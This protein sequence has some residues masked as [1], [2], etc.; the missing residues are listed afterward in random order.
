[1]FTQADREGVRGWLVDR[2]QADPRV[3]AAA[4]MGSGADGRE[5]PWSD[6]DLALRLGPAVDLRTVADDWTKQIGAHLGTVAHVDVWARGAL[7]RVFVLPDTLQVDVSF[8][9]DEDFA[10][11]GPRFRLV[12]GDANEPATP[13]TTTTA[14]DDTVG[15]A[16]LHAIHVRSSLA[17]GRVLQALY[18][19]NAVR[20]YVV[21]LACRRH[22]LPAHEGRGVDD[23]PPDLTKHLAET[24]PGSLELDRLRDAFSRLSALL[25]RE[26]RYVDPAV[27]DRLDPLL[28]ELVRTADP[29]AAPET[30]ASGG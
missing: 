7:Y 29:Q 9:P 6:I 16:W 8:W 27:A 18:F 30:T 24:I 1:V 13:S 28:A 25:V 11:H 26:V 5:D 4:I 14:D 20:E 12:F 22:G 19:L 17:R 2:A 3:I 15:M 23:L 21:Q 10:A